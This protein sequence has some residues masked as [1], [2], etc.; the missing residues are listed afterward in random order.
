M[1]L[2]WLL[3]CSILLALITAALYRWGTP[4]M[5][6]TARRWWHH[7]RQ[8]P[9]LGV[10]P[11]TL[12]TPVP[13]STKDTMLPPVVSEPEPEPGLE[14]E[15]EPIQRSERDLPRS[16]EPELQEV[17]MMTPLAQ[18]LEGDEALYQT[19]ETETSS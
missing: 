1:L 10:S 19:I 8:G 13:D 2:W 17:P 7:I 5:L 15:P 4:Q 12:S 6:D 18:L 16:I 14:P 9:P 3:F 11:S